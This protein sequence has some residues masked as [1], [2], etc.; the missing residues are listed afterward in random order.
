MDFYVHKGNK[1]GG[2]MHPA[3]TVLRPM[4][5]WHGIKEKE[6]KT[7]LWVSLQMEENILVRFS[8]WQGRAANFAF[9]HMNFHLL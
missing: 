8:K 5:T 2:E 7:L 9:Q 4:I 1:K 3:D 6:N